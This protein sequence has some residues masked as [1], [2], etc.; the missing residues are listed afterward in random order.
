MVFI[1]LQLNIGFVLLHI[2]LPFAHRRASS[3]LAL[4]VKGF[5]KDGQAV[6]DIRE[7]SSLQRILAC[8]VE[9]YADALLDRRRALTR[10]RVHGAVDAA[11]GA[12]RP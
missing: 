12:T 11:A 1:Q 4:K 5:K 10:C 9:D 8:L 3:L 7:R 6:E 2:W